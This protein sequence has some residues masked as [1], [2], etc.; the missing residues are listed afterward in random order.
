VEEQVDLTLQEHKVLI[1]QQQVEQVIPAF[2]EML[3]PVEQEEH[4]QEMETQA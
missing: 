4:L 3:E 2:Q 1:A